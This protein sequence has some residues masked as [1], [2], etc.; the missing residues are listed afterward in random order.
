[1]NRTLLE[2]PEKQKQISPQSD[3][4][5]NRLF[6]VLMIRYTHKWASQF[7]GETEEEV[8][9][10]V[11][12]AKQV[13]ASGLSGLTKDQIKHGLDLSVEAHPSWP[14]LLGEF[15]LLCKQGCQDIELRQLSLPDRTKKAI[16]KDE[17][18]SIIG[19]HLPNLHL[20]LKG[21][22]VE[23][24]IVEDEQMAKINI[25]KAKV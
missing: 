13:W 16:T 9:E 18:I 15:K 8:D 14:P 2:Y 20:A 19:K 5:I 4:V 22:Y 23:K 11:E 12:A 10:N 6:A 3:K 17:R 7:A 1:V 25:N 24:D 21:E